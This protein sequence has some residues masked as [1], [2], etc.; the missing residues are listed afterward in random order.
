M[1]KIF[2]TISSLAVITFFAS[3]DKHMDSVATKHVTIDTAL[4]PGQ[5][6]QLPLARYSDADD[7]ATILTQGS[8]YTVSAITNLPRTFAPVY[9]YSANAAKVSLTDQVVLAVTEGNRNG[10][11]NCRK[12]SD[13]TIITLNFTVK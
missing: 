12:N 13:S 7:V 2:Y 5:V 4:T 6:Y 9:S 10:N 1:K 8:N 11:G 3:C